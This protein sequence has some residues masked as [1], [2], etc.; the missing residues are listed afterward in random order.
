MVASLLVNMVAHMLAEHAA[1]RM[2]QDIAAALPAC[3]NTAC[4]LQ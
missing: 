2:L 1:A 3:A 4:T